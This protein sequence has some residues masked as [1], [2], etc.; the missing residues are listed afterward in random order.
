MSLEPSK[1]KF[2]R[3]FIIGLLLLMSTITLRAQKLVDV[4]FQTN[5]SR[6]TF[7]SVIRTFSTDINATSGTDLYKLTYETTGTDGMKDTAS[8]LFILPDIIDGPLPLLNYQHGTTDGRDDVPSNQSGQE[9]LLASLFGA[10]GFVTLAPDYLGMGESRGFHPYVNS[11]TEA[12]AMIDMLAA[13]KEYLQ[14]ND[15]AYTDQL[16][17]TGYSQGGHGAMAAHKAIEEG[18]MADITT[19]VTASL[20]MSGP[21]SISGVMR[22]LTL[23]DK[24]F[25]FPSYLVYTMLGAKAI[26]PEL[27]SDISEI[28]RPEF[29]SAIRTFE[30]TGNGL[31]AMN[32]ELLSILESEFGASLPRFL[33]TDEVIQALTNDTSSIYNRIL[34]DNDLYNWKPEAPVY[35]LYCQSDDQVPFRNSVVADSVMNEL[36][37]IDVSSKDVSGGRMLSHSD[38]ILPALIEG[39]PWLLSFLDN[40]TPTVNLVSNSESLTLYPNPLR[41]FL[42]VKSSE[43]DIENI[44]LYNINGQLIRTTDKVSKE[45]RIDMRGLQ[46]GWYIVKIQTNEGLFSEKIIKF[47]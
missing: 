28:F 34:R 43:S 31:S 17:I 11:E 26:E 47:N 18:Q 9:F 21:Y 45:I 19:S 25:F 13:V 30:R 44:Q 2:Y 16:F 23:G 40:A 27:Y 46:E 6:A 41:D 38:C 12:R 22:D 20:P 1:F 24:E 29:L 7:Q 14:E 10:L 32:R 8:G 39:I 15:I 3:L 4:R 37:A 42:Y 36:G 33:F 35:M 5:I